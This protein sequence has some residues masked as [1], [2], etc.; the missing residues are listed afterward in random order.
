MTTSAAV[1][2]II[3]SFASTSSFR[4]VS[5]VPGPAAS[6]APIIVARSSSGSGKVQ[7]KRA[8]NARVAFEADRCAKVSLLS[9][10]LDMDPRVALGEKRAYLAQAT[11]ERYIAL[12]LVAKVQARVEPSWG[13]LSSCA[14][15]A[16]AP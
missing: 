5:S 6:V 7:P 2:L 1:F 8:K 14:A 15:P 4:S 10:E 11:V 16:Y 3:T 9:R 12:T 13:A